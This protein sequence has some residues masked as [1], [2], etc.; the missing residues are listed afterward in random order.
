[1]IWESFLLRSC[2]WLCT[3]SQC[4]KRTPKCIILQHFGGKIQILRTKTWIEMRIE[5]KKWN[6]LASL[7]NLKNETFFDNFQTRWNRVGQTRQLI[8]P[9]LKTS[10]DNLESTLGKLLE[11][12]L[13]SLIENKYFAL[14]TTLE[15]TGENLLFSHSCRTRCMSKFLVMCKQI[16]KHLVSWKSLAENSTRLTK[17]FAENRGHTE[18]IFAQKT[19]NNSRAPASTFV[20]VLRHVNSS[21]LNRNLDSF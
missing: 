16:R 19:I 12:V 4:L 2:R 7:A 1:M 3:L 14:F 11:S 18:K 8:F 21:Y 5:I 20:C 6:L 17:E 13:E 10:K 9:P 15:F